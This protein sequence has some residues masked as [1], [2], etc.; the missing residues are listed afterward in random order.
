M[1]QGR[2][3]R[4]AP[5]CILCAAIAGNSHLEGDAQQVAHGLI[6]GYIGPDHKVIDMKALFGALVQALEATHQQGRTQ[7]ADK[8]KRKQMEQSR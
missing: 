3:L 2:S 7:S 6:Q 5:F 8:A 4:R 1:G